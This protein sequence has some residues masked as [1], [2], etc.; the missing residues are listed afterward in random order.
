MGGGQRVAPFG[1]FNMSTAFITA[2]TREYFKSY[3]VYNGSG[4]LIDQYDAPAAARH[5]HA[6]LRTTF[7]YVSSR[8]VKRLEAESTWDSTWDI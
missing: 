5:G 2:G 6:C 3:L 4:E 8:V 1:V 7:T